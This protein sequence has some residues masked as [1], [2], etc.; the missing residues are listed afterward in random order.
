M[1]T[2]SMII[3]GYPSTL[4]GQGRERHNE[5]AQYSDKID[6]ILLI[7]ES[8]SMRYNDPHGFRKE[9]A[10][11]FIDLEAIPGDQV[12]VIGFCENARTLASMTEVRGDEEKIYLKNSIDQIHSAGEWTDFN[13]GLEAAFNEYSGKKRPDVLGGVILLT[14][15]QMDPDAKNP[16]YG[17]NKEMAIRYLFEK[18]VPLYRESGLPVYTIALSKDANMTLLQ[19]ISNATAGECFEAPTYNDLP[20]IYAQIFSRMKDRKAVDKGEYTLKPGSIE[21]IPVYVEDYV[22]EIIFLVTKADPAARVYIEDPKGI[23]IGPASV[24]GSRTFYAGSHSYDIFTVIEPQEGT[25]N[26]ILDG[27]GVQSSVRMVA[28]FIVYT[29]VELVL[30]EIDRSYSLNAKV[31]IRA[32]LMQNEERITERELLGNVSFKLF[33]FR[34]NGDKDEMRMNDEGTSGDA[35]EG[36]GVYSAEYTHTDISGEY[37]AEVVAE[38]EIIRKA[39][40]AK[41]EILGEPLLFVEPS[42]AELGKIRKGDSAELE[43][44]ITSRGEAAETL[45]TSVESTTMPDISEYLF[46]E[47]ERIDIK[48]N[49]VKEET[50]IVRPVGLKRG[51]YNAAII[52]TPTSGK[53]PYENA[54]ID[55]NF[56]VAGWWDIYAG[57]VITLILLAALSALLAGYFWLRR[58]QLKG[59]LRIR[60]GE[61]GVPLEYELKGAKMTMGN[62]EQDDIRITDDLAIRPGHLIFKATKRGVLLISSYGEDSEVDVLSINDV[63]YAGPI[64]LEQGDKLNIG[65]TII[66][67]EVP[68][69]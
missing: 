8:G 63:A 14:D 58:P 53:S 33:V 29:N 12:G 49:T 17:N 65:E 31:T 55:I 36:D 66:E 48:G 26:I 42:E 24:D 43:I 9:A 44:R 16:N 39:A 52:L 51:N 67:Y 1:I 21:R 45:A 50:L 35:T 3:V 54:R 61:D 41:F 6:A 34:P 37:M 47:P 18:V 68:L 30:P 10:K 32:Q 60:V 59:I 25:W 13:V 69:Y 15:G 7:D 22:K 19:Q 38:S 56:R 20:R 4:L 28:Q 46:V 62:S 57:L 5:Q 64:R 11:L 27:T 40:K 23:S 2:I